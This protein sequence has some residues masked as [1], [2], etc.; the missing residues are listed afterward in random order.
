MNPPR[1]LE[2]DKYIINKRKKLDKLK[3]EHEKLLAS[4]IPV[5]DSDSEIKILNSELC[6]L[7]AEICVVEG[8]EPE[9][10]PNCNSFLYSWVQHTLK[11]DI[12][13]ME[14][15]LTNQDNIHK[16]SMKNKELLTKMSP[17][18]HDETDI[19]RLEDERSKNE[20]L[21]S[22]HH[23]LVRRLRRLSRLFPTYSTNSKKM[24]T[25]IRNTSGEVLTKSFYRVLKDF[26]L[27]L[28]DRTFTSDDWE[29]IN[30]VPID[31]TYSKEH[32]KL[33]CSCGIIQRSKENDAMFH[34][35]NS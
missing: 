29:K 13:G 8:S 17:A 12:K 30:F 3:A 18:L 34:L 2:L 11:E 22:L 28:Q 25:S 33:L 26:V 32:I 5:S 16:E 4:T 31:H 1:M 6:K 35:K 9:T 23:K 15:I 21:Q 24:K 27:E 7:Q 14:K 10:M 20:L 19:R